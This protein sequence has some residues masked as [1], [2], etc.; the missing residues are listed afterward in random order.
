[1]NNPKL[2]ANYHYALKTYHPSLTKHLPGKIP[3]NEIVCGFSSASVNSYSHMYMRTIEAKNKYYSIKE[4]YSKEVKSILSSNDSS[5][6]TYQSINNFIDSLCLGN[7][8][9]S[10]KIVPHQ[11]YEEYTEYNDSK[12][13]DYEFDIFILKSN[14][15]SLPSKVDYM[16]LKV[17]DGTLANNFFS[18]LAFYDKDLIITYWVI[19]W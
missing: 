11:L 13:I 5:I 15:V 10:Y 2:Q 1:M 3:N 18:G 7:K 17:N 8:I 14:F 16:N 12:L 6:Q 9:F 4:Q 19:T